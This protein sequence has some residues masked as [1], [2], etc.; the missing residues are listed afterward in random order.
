[1][2]ALRGIAQLSD[3]LL[4][5]MLLAYWRKLLEL[6]HGEVRKIHL[7][8]TSVN[9]AASVSVYKG[10]GTFS[11]LGKE[12]PRCWDH[13]RAPN[14]ERGCPLKTPIPLHYDPKTAKWPSLLTR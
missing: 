13:R 11:G 5:H 4:T 3:C 7:P 12:R 9:K 6:R 8:R 10:V 14:S 2:T 1:M